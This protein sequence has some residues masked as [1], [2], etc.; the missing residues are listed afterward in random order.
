[1]GVGMA[2]V[3]DRLVVHYSSHLGTQDADY[4][5]PSAPSSGSAAPGSLV[6][7]LEAAV[8]KLV[9]LQSC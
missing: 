9:G 3:R 2:S 7:T 6:G 8:H 4:G 5:L 1:M